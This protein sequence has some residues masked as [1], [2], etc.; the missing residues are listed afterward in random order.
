[1]SGNIL[2]ILQRLGAKGSFDKLPANLERLMTERK[3]LDFDGNP[4]TKISF[5]P[6]TVLFSSRKGEM[7]V[8]KRMVH[9]TAQSN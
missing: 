7:I 8:G 3:F 2:N 5:V 4:S 6:L 1:M 9:L